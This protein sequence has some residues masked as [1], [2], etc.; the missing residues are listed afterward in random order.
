MKST[1]A[2]VTV[3]FALT[4]LIQQAALCADAPDLSARFFYRDHYATNSK[5]MQLLLDDVSAYYTAARHSGP[6][7]N[8]EPERPKALTFRI[9]TKQ[10]TQEV[11]WMSIPLSAM[12]SV[13]LQWLPLPR[14]TV[15]FKNIRISRKGGGSDSVDMIVDGREYRYVRTDKNG[16]V[17]Q[18]IKGDL[19][20]RIDRTVSAVPG[21]YGADVSYE[22]FAFCGTGPGKQRP[23][24]PDNEWII[25][26][27]LI[28]RVE[29]IENVDANQVPEDT[30]R[31]LADPQR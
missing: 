23:H 24:S 28:D 11:Q 22:W 21:G 8:S 19:E 20:L 17:Q 30:A 2:S 27:E 13:D 31:K 18:D 1:S 6:G 25:R 4:T 26:K 29:F 10:P 16:V 9:L 15:G 7:Q 5:K 12:T 14:S 3:A